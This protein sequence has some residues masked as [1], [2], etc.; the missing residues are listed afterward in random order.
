MIVKSSSVGSLL[1]ARH[2][3]QS[4]DPP[5]H[6]TEESSVES[7]CFFQLVRV[8]SQEQISRIDQVAQDESEHLSEVET[9]DHLFERLLSGLVGRLVD[10]DVILGSREML[11]FERVECSPL[12]VD[13]HTGSLGQSE[14][15]HLGYVLRGLHVCSV[16]SSTKDDSDLCVWVNV[17][18][19]DEG[20]GGVVDQGSELNGDILAVSAACARCYHLQVVSASP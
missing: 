15:A 5:L 7:V 2:H 12:A 11:M 8:L 17:V 4:H 18:G 1:S 20:S 3:H 19:G 6:Q 14:S 10:D 13:S 16:A 9:G